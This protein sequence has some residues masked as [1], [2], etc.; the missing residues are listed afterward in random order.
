MIRRPRQP[1]RRVVTLF[2]ETFMS[3]GI[4][5]DNAMLRA[6]LVAAI[7]DATEREGYSCEIVAVV[8]TRGTDGRT[9]HQHAITL[10]N[11]GERLAL[12]DIVFALGHPSFFR[13]LVFASVGAHEACRTTWHTQGYPTAAFDDRHT[14]GHSE[15]YIKQLSIE[16]QRKLNDDDPY[17]MLRFIEPDGLPVSLRDALA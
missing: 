2:V 8:T 10:K 15:F 13:R 1:G 6:V 12:A 5:P 14:C 11:A 17:D 9:G 16:D 4:D 3:S 7:A